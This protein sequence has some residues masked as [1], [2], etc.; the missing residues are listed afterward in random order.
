MEQRE[1]IAAKVDWR[2]PLLEASLKTTFAG[3]ERLR[4]R[5]R[6]FAGFL[7]EASANR[8]VHA[9]EDIKRVWNEVIDR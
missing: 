4:T 1:V 6:K 9:S 3:Y 5:T 2:A 8:A 7:T